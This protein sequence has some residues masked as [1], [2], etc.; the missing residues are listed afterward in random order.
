MKIKNNKVLFYGPGDYLSPQHVAKF[1]VHGI[2]YINF[3]QYIGYQKAKFAEDDE[4]MK[5]ILSTSNIS[6]ILLLSRRVREDEDW[7][8]I[9]NEIAY[10]GIFSKFQQN[11]RF[12]ND[13]IKTNDMELL[14]IAPFDTY[15]GTGPIQP[16]GTFLG[17]NH[18]GQILMKVRENLKD[19]LNQ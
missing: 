15:W 11:I 5:K 8:N 6:N 10:E 19:S 1:N 2:T 7:V 3:D 17:M 12:V 4:R 16:N 9:V 14:H 13:L 18:Y